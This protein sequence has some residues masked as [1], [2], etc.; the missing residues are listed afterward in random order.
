[1]IKS[2]ISLIS[3]LDNPTIML[4]YKQVE[5]SKMILDQE[6]ESMG[7]IVAEQIVMLANGIALAERLG[8]PT[9]GYVSQIFAWIDNAI[10]TGQDPL[11]RSVRNA[12]ERGRGIL[13]ENGVGADVLYSLNISIKGM[14]EI[15]SESPL[16]QKPELD[17]T[18]RQGVEQSV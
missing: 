16:P 10:H 12:S 8:T 15:L 4:E 2:E 13:M 14:S 9:T 6:L 7:E 1:L 17:Q 18:L 11:I 5:R 3:S